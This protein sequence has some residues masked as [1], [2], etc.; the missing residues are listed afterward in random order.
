MVSTHTS[1]PSQRPSTLHA[2]TL[3]PGPTWSVCLVFYFFLSLWFLAR[4]PN[5][6]VPSVLTRVSN[7]LPFTVC[8]SCPHFPPTPTLAFLWSTS[9]P[10]LVLP[11]LRRDLTYGRRRAGTKSGGIKYNIQIYRQR[12]KALEGL[13]TGINLNQCGLSSVRG[14]WEFQFWVGKAERKQLA[15]FYPTMKT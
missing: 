7:R 8:E 2:S 14:G 6:E 12:V 9:A 3:V 4:S 13:R 11:Q 10:T 5:S 1:G 15:Y